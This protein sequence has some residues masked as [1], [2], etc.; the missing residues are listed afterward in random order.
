MKVTF[1]RRRVSGTME[2]CSRATFLHY[3]LQLLTG[4]GTKNR[5]C[6]VQCKYLQIFVGSHE[7]SAVKYPNALS[8]MYKGFFL[9]FSFFIIVLHKKTDCSK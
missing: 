1:I 3:N 7:K 8:F 2:K 9:Q 5:C 6:C 4:T